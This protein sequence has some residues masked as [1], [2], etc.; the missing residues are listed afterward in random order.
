MEPSLSGKF[1]RANQRGLEILTVFDQLGAETAHCTVLFCTVSMRHHDRRRK[2]MAGGCEC[3][4][5]PKIPPVLLQPLPGFG[6]F[7]Q[8]GVRM[9]PDLQAD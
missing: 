7:S 8:V 6:E 3:H 4:R 9:T 5:L 1:L 2:S